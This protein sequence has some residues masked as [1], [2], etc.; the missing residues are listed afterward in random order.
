M[1]ALKYN[2]NSFENS[3]KQWYFNIYFYIIFVI[4]GYLKLHFT[5]IY[6]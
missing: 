2:W 1:A 3:V 5:N 6:K 4:S